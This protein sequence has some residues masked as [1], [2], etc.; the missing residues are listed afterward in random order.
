MK[1]L[2]KQKIP[3]GKQIVSFDVV[4]LFT[5]VPLE[6]TIN[7]IIKRIYDKNKINTNILKRENKE[8]LYLYTK[9]VHFTLNSKTYVQIDG[10]AIGSPPGPVLA[11]IFMVEL[12]QNMIPTLPNDKLL[13]KRYQPCC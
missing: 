13:W 12:E 11:N 6:E 10:V 5:N 7:I 8:L 9:N 2:K 3:P 1:T 4:A